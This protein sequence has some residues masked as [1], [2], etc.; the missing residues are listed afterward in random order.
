MDTGPRKSES[1]ETLVNTSS[2]HSQCVSLPK[3]FFD[4]FVRIAYEE[5]TH[6]TFLTEQLQEYGTY[7]GALPIH[8]GLWDSATSTAHDIL[9]R[10]AIVHMLSRLI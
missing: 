4:D 9:A 1:F 5:A 10:L 7:F 3:A 6:F 8:D 2:M